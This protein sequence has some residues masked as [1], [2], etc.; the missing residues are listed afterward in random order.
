M[1]AKNP[2]YRQ[3]HRHPVRPRC[4][5]LSRPFLALEPFQPPINVR[6]V[7]RGVKSAI[8]HPQRV[9]E[10]R[11]NLGEYS[12][13]CGSARGVGSIPRP[14]QV[15]LAVW[16]YSP[17]CVALRPGATIILGFAAKNRVRSISLAYWCGR[18]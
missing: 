15:A 4:G 12:V 13:G 7:V 14:R 3:D 5:F 9:G 2:G 16:R 18:S 10:Q 6:R 8:L 11:L 17:Q 1:V